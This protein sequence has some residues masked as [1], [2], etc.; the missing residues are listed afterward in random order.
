[1]IDRQRKQVELLNT[2]AKADP[3]VVEYLMQDRANEIDETF[4]AMLR[5]Y[6]E[7]AVAEQ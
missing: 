7:T 3:D 2:M 6:V 4:F 5:S 1:M